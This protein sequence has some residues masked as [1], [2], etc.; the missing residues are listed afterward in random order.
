MKRK[1]LTATLL[2]C[3]SIAIFAGSGGEDKKLSYIA[4]GTGYSQFN[5]IDR[6]VSPLVYSST[7]SPNCLS[8]YH[9]SERSIF[10]ADID[11]VLSYVSPK[12]F[13]ERSFIN[14]G[15]NHNGTLKEQAVTFGK[16]L[17]IQDEISI[18][19]LRLI[20]KN[21]N[22]KMNLLFGGRFNQYFSYASTEAP[23]FVFSE[24]SLNP[25][26]LLR[27]RF[28][29]TFESQTGLSVPLLSLIT[30]MP[31]SNDPTDGEHNYF[32]SSFLMGSHLASLNRFQRVNFQQSLIK[33]FNHRW[34]VALDYNFYW[35]HYRNQSDIN[36]YDNS[37]TAKVLISLNSKK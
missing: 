16:S 23:V 32:V 30:Q 34:A 8:F 13:S 6:K 5:M 36:A 31:Y 22:G 29:E 14:V 4:I 19:Y 17:L 18:E 27:Y 26:L 3:C 12:D 25:S 28:S 1:F 20:K 35:F 9:S 10:R 11:F 2:L 7:Q 24:L 15:P 37:I 21:E 33:R